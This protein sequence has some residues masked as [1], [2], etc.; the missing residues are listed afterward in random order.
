MTSMPTEEAKT[1]VA[2]LEIGP[3]NWGRTPKSP[4][5]YKT[6]A[7]EHHIRALRRTP[8]LSDP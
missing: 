4:V 8:V 1:A 2:L 5:D 7:T 6:A 3:E